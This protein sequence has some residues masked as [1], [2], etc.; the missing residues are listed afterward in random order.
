MSWR[1]AYIPWYRIAEEVLAGSI[2]LL[3]DKEIVKF[4]SQNKWLII[5]SGS[6][7][8]KKDSIIRSDANIY[9]DLS[10]AGEITIGFVCNTLESVRRMRNLLHGFHTT[11]KDNF[12][13]ELQLLDDRYTTH[14]ERKIK[15]YHFAQTPEYVKDFEFTTNRINDVLLSQA[16]SRIDK[17]MEESDINKRTTGKSW[18]TLAP[19]IN[20]ARVV[21]GRNQDEFRE[22]LQQLKP[23][24]QIALRIKTDK[25]ITIAKRKKRKQE[26]RQKKYNA[27]IQNLKD[28]PIRARKYR[29]AIE[30][31]NKENP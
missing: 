20:I 27:F 12:I 22:A 15:A 26:E 23:A 21:I 1:N 24:Y 16:F 9:F 2:P 3:N 17:I 5:P 10:K 31:W 4:V 19:T 7:K 8:D 30:K 25:E 29:D 11:E 18:R 6:E 13:R 28:N 14:I